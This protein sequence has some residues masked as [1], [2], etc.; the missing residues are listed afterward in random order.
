M[1]LFGESMGNLAAS[2]NCSAIRTL[3]IESSST[4]KSSTCESTSMDKRLCLFFDIERDCWGT[5]T[6]RCGT[7]C[8]RRPEKL[9]KKFEIL[10]I[11][12]NDSELRDERKAARLEQ[13]RDRSYLQLF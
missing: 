9:Q 6:T 11:T 7:H 1:E 10:I 5:S 4:C 2:F 3:S 12:K 8:V 13:A